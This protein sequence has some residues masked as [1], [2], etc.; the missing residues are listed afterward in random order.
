MTAEKTQPADFA[1]VAH[2]HARAFPGSDPDRFLQLWCEVAQILGKSPAEL[3]ESDV[4]TTRPARELFLDDTM[5]DLVTLALRNSRGTP[6]GKV[7]TVGQLLAF[8]LMETEE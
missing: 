7:E 1:S 6:K 4:L 5:E 8:L 2:I 3:H